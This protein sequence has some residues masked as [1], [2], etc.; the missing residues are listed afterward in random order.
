MDGRTNISP[1]EH[2]QHGEI[3]YAVLPG[4]VRKEILAK[5]IIVSHFRSGVLHLQ[6][7][8]SSRPTLG[9]IKLILARWTSSS[10]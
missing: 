2:L 7:T 9:N 6:Q 10:S 4:I 5:E 1:V 8:I 3:V